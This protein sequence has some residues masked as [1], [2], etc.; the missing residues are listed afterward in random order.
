MNRTVLLNSRFRF[1]RQFRTLPIALAILS[2]VFTNPVIAQEV[3]ERM[4]R[5]LT[6]TGESE[7]MIP[8]TL[9]QVELGVE[10]RGETATGVQQEVA[11]RTAAVVEL[12]RSRDVEQLQTTGIRLQ[13]LYDYEDNE[14][15]LLG[16]V[17]TNTVSFRINT[18]QAGEIIDAAVQA[19]AT[20]IDSVSFTATDSA[21]SAAQKE[22][23]REA[24]QD[25]QQQA[26]AVFSTLNLTG[27]EVVS[28]QVNGA[29]AP[30]P[31]PVPVAEFRTE[32]ADTTTPVIGGEQTVRASVTLKISY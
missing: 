4:L 3:Q 7:E 20:R 17:G 15:R 28:I 25:A 32:A 26:D 8:A 16:Y 9:T 21:I 27:E 29:S 30:P 11:R 10:I 18:E 24:T 19:G 14:R 22:A 5:T 2:L 12:L 23:L 1:G 31:P 13:P 6:V